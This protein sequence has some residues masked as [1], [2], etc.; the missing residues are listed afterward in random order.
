MAQCVTCNLGL[1]TRSVGRPRSYCSIE[2]RRAEALRLRSLRRPVPAWRLA[3]QMM[4]DSR[5]N[6]ND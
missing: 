5:R 1:P 2:C 3:Y 4:Q 6:L